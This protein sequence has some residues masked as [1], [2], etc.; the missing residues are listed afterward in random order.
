MDNALTLQHED[1]H[2]GAGIPNDIALLRV[3]DDITTGSSVREIT[4]HQE[5]EYINENSCTIT[6]WGQTSGM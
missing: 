3:R 6:G 5:G 4:L 2:T 1:Y